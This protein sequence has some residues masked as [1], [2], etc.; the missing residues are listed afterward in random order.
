MVLSK[1]DHNSDH[2]KATMY[3]PWSMYLNKDTVN[4]TM[5]ASI[6]LQLKLDLE[7]NIMTEHCTIYK[8]LEKT[9]L[10]TST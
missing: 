3:I 9:V 7:Y 2:P 6:L 1:F 10:I 5:T 4:I 8:S